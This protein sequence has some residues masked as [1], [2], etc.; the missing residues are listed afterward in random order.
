MFSIGF[1]ELLVIAVITLLVVGPER[2]PETIRFVTLNLAKFKRYWQST[3]R[4]IEKDL[5]LADIR[6]EIHNA[7]VMEHLEETKKK[8]NKPLESLTETEAAESSKKESDLVEEVLAEDK[9][10]LPADGEP[11]IAPAVDKEGEPSADREPSA[12]DNIEPTE[13]SIAPK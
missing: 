4:D 10:E 13:N 11:S 6:R 3:R 5:G 9:K 7:A 1:A 8:L 2:L 12:K